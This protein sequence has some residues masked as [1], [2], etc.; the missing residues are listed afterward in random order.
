MAETRHVVPREGGWAV[1]GADTDRMSS[2]HATQ[3]E[4]IERAREVVRA[5]GGGE[6]VIHMRDGRIRDKDTVFPGPKE[7]SRQSLS[8]DSGSPSS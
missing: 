1:R 6:I 4:A 3:A 8:G 7:S 2:V 5:A